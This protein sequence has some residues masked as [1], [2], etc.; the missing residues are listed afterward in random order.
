MDSTTILFTPAQKN[1]MDILADRMSYVIPSYQRPYS[2][3]S[4][5][6]SGKD[7]QVNTLWEDLIDFFNSGNKNIYFMGSMVVIGNDTDRVFEVVDGQQRLTTLSLLFAAMNCFFHQIILE[8]IEAENEEKKLLILNQI[9]TAKDAIDRFIYNPADLGLLAALNR[10][11]KLKIARTNV[12]KNSVDYDAILKL[13]LECALDTD[14]RL[15]KLLENANEEQ[16]NI[17]NRYFKNRKF[18]VSELQSEFMP[19]GFFNEFQ[20]KRLA[21][22]V[23]FLQRRVTIIRIQAT[24]PSIAFQVFEILNN[25]GL[26]LTNKDLLRNFVISKFN[27][28]Q[29][30]KNSLSSSSPF[31][32][33]QHLEINY[34]FDTEF[35]N[36]YVESKQGEKQ[37]LSAF[38]DVTKR[39]YEQIVQSAKKSKIEILYEDIENYLDIYTKIVQQKF[40]NPL[41]NNRVAFLL[42]TG[43]TS[44][45]MN[46]LIALFVNTKKEE[47]IL[48]FLRQFELYAL[49]MLIGAPRFKFA[50]LFD[51][52][53]ELNKKNFIEA[54][55][56]LGLE[57]DDMLKISS[58]LN[59][60]H[61]N[62]VGTLLIARYYWA[63]EHET[64]LA[65]KI[66]GDDI[67]SKRL[68]FD[69]ATLEHIIPQ[70][71]A[72]NTN[73]L[74]DFSEN[75]RK[76][77]TYKLGN[78]T[79]LP[80][81]LNR[82]AKNSSFE[83]KKEAYQ[84]S[85]FS[86]TIEVFAQTSMSEQYI[87][88]RHE[89]ILALLRKDLGL[90][91]VPQS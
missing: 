36:R 4:V 8:K 32:K 91:N 52:V 63:K 7:N 54:G 24:S 6:G 5:G 27:E 14:N 42:N 38:N 1:L 48:T 73:W 23:D 13:A 80:I 21:E 82:A 43:N 77:Y 20:F 50:T 78:M 28:L 68:F 16:K 3:E 9:K 59:N 15:K 47:I 71:P 79:L 17:A 62:N 72:K 74:K 31:E 41:I 65:L 45:I 58:A 64:Y 44:Y 89:D 53:K 46:V 10:E 40:I 19:N 51:V 33:W 69:K 30:Q 66:K 56:K 75:F 57:S 55:Q 37:R 35:I 49:Q 11:Y 70:N 67:V 18:F 60:N 39:I 90:P 25:R 81:D 88:K 29:E 22:F 84:H 86:L 76:L 83:K 12:N 85:G 26:P 61:E 2:W 34:Q 87:K